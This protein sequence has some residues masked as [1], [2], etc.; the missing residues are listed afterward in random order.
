MNTVYLIYRTWES[1]GFGEEK[2]RKI[3]GFTQTAEAAEKWIDENQPRYRYTWF[4]VEEVSHLAVDEEFC[5]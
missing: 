4:E 3:V 1:A 2:P 5:R